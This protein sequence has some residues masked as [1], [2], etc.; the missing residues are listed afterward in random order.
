MGASLYLEGEAFSGAF[1]AL[2][3]GGGIETR[4]VS[5]LCKF[6]LEIPFRNQRCTRKLIFLKLGC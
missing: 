6:H 1:Q 3:I 5:D 4:R 2:S